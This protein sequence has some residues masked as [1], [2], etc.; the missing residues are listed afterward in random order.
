VFSSAKALFDDQGYSFTA[1][2]I[3]IGLPSRGPRQCDL[4]ARKIVGGRRSSVFPAPVRAALNETTY[5]AA[6]K[7]SKRASG[8][9]LSKQAFAILPK[10]REVDDYLRAQPASIAGVREVHP[11]VCFTYWNDRQPMK[12]RKLSGFGFVERFKLVDEQFPSAAERIRRECEASKV[13]DDDI[14]DALSALWTA[15]RLA[16]S[17]A[18]CIGGGAKDEHGL[19][20]NM[21][22]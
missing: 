8:K 3:P 18:V 10:I 20:M 22:A 9:K 4:E 7:K 19:P 6:C 21:W 13:A 16:A 2:D 1:I 14:L 5:E 11:E 17:T 12:Y 15:T